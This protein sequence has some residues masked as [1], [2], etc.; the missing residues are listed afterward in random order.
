MDANEAFKKARNYLI[1]EPILADWAS[2]QPILILPSNS[3]WAVAC[4]YKRRGQ[5]QNERAIIFINNQGEVS[6]FG[7]V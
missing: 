7:K 2:I 5:S 6:G 1:Q 3:L 4:D